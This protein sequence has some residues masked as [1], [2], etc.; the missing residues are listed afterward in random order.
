VHRDRGRIIDPQHALLARRQAEFGEKTP[1]R[2]GFFRR[3]DLRQALLADASSPGAMPISTG[4]SASA[5][6]LASNRKT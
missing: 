2:R 5:L 1:G 6:P 4:A 3:A